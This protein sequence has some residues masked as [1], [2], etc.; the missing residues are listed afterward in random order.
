MG[1]DTSEVTL[2]L[3]PYLKVYKDGTLERIAGVEV[4][5]GL[6]LQTNILSKDILIVPQ[7]SV[8]ARIYLPNFVIKDQKIPFVMYFHGGAFCVASPAFPNYHNSLNKLVAEANIVA[9]SVSYRLVPEHSLPTA[10]QDSWPALQ[11]VASHEEEDGHHHE[12]WIKDYVDLDQV[13]LVSDSAGANIAHHLS[14]RSR[15][16]IWISGG[17]GC[18]DP[19]INPFVDGSPDLV[20][21]ACH[22]ILVIVAKKDILRD[23]GRFYYDKLVKSG[24]RRKAEILQNEGEDHVFHI[25]NPNC[26]KAKSL[27]KCLATFL[28]QGLGKGI[29]E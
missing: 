27:M 19:F 29:V 6:D 28:N 8:S 5:P 24:W 10:Y 18:D 1:S 4:V 12:G 14:L 17:K 23:R 15:N 3:F 16:R 26:D 13:F 20:G 11:W 22:G 21:L 25:F 2:D 9:L 7:T